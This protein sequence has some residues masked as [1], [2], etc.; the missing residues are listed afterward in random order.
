[1]FRLLTGNAH[2]C[3]TRPQPTYVPT[4]PVMPTHEFVEGVRRIVDDSP[5]PVVLCSQEV[6]EHM[7]VD[8]A[9]YMGMPYFTFA[10]MHHLVG[11]ETNRRLGLAI[12]STLP[13]T[14]VAVPRAYSAFGD[15]IPQCWDDLDFDG[16][17]TSAIWQEATVT[18]DGVVYRIGNTHFTQSPGGQSTPPQ[19]ASLDRLLA[20][21]D[22]GLC[23]GDAPRSLVWCGD[24]NMP[25]GSH[26]G[27]DRVCQY[28]TDNIPAEVDNSLDL[29][30]HNAARERGVR[31]MVDGI[32]ST[33][34]L[35][36][37]GFRAYG[38]LSDHLVF[39]VTVQY[40]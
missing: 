23:A 4:E 21:M 19:M 31:V 27:W 10:P 36:V 24:M 8:M 13:F 33:S 28:Y 16:L 37:G 17:P 7:V 35:E 34:D 39:Q 14:K 22:S 18:V 29:R 2:Y 40:A 25:R 32:F 5:L 3:D 20:T 26:P 12:F 6:M 1:M 11:G 9:A 15:F 38:D 30:I